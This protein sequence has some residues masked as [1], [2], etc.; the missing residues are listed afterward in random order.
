MVVRHF[1]A[2]EYSWDDAK[3]ARPMDLRPSCKSM[4]QARDRRVDKDK[5]N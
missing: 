3:E 5:A 1:A 4:R 2:A